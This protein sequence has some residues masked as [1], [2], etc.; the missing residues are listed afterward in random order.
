[1]VPVKELVKEQFG[2]LPVWNVSAIDKKQAL[3]ALIRFSGTLHL[4][5]AGHVRTSSD[6]VFFG[7]P[8]IP[9]FLDL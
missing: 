2:T 1:M 4:D 9:T 3:D 7:Y 8:H 5:P 6:P